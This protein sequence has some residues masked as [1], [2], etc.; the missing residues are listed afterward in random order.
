MNGNSST[1]TCFHP[2]MLLL[3]SPFRTPSQALFQSEKR[4]SSGQQE[5]PSGL[6]YH[7]TG[8][9]LIILKPSANSAWML[10]AHGKR[11]FVSF[12]V[13]EDTPAVTGSKTAQTEHATLRK[14]KF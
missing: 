10:P 12:R 11:Q 6:K 1:K 3:F 2:T 13:T 9:A 8:I 14:E 7:R 4:S 5:D